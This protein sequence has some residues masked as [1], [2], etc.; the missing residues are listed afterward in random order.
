MG[1]TLT[2]KTGSQAHLGDLEI[3]GKGIDKV[4]P[5]VKPEGLPGVDWAVGEHV[6][7][8]WTIVQ[9]PVSCELW[10]PGHYKTLVGIQPLEVYEDKENWVFLFACQ[11]VCLFVCLGF[12]FFGKKTLATI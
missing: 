7:E 9:S 8:L 12:F 5:I 11:F 1:A 6:R 3:S 2:P 4:L 10:S